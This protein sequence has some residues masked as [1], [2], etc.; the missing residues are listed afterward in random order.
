MN[1]ILV[2]AEER[3][4]CESLRAA[5]PETDLLF[6]EA[7]T[8]HVVRRLTS[9]RP[10]MVI[11]DD[12]PGLGQQTLLKVVEAAPGASCL[13]LSSRRDSETLA[14]FTLAGARQCIVKPFS[15]DELRSAVQHVTGVVPKPAPVNVPELD[16]QSSASA[17]NQHQMALRWLGRT[18]GHMQNPVRISQ[19]LVDA[20]V[21]IFDAVRSAVLL[22]QQGLVRIVASHGIPEAVTAQLRL[23][24]SSGLMRSFD[25][26]ACLIDRGAA[27]DAPAAAKEMQVLGAR[28]AVPILARGRVCGAILIG[29]KASGSDYTLEEKELLSA[30][31]R[32]ASTSFDNAQLYQDLSRQQTRLDTVLANITAGVVTVL[33]NKCVGMMNQSAE[34]I[35][36]LRAVDVL[37]RSVQKLGSGFADM[38]LRTLADGTPRL[39]QEIQDP[40]INATLGL[41][42]TPLGDQGVV[43]I[44][45]K[46]PGEKIAT[47]DVAYSPFWEY[48]ASR[49]AQEIKNPMVAVNT[50]AQL[51]PKKYDSEDFRTA[52]ADVVQK[53][54]SR[55]NNVVETLFDFAQHPRLVLQ[56]ANVQSTVQNVLE[57]FQQELGLRNISLRMEWD[58]EVTEAELDPIHFCRAVHNVVQNSIEAMPGGGTLE[59]ATHREGKN[60]ELVISDTGPG[61]PAQDASLV[62]MPFFSTKERGMGLGLTVANRI[63]EQHE[64][65]LELRNTNHKGG[66]F[67]LRLPAGGKGAGTPSET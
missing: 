44:F 34:R 6:F 11:V 5:L 65:K 36:Q 50:F 8:E 53:E 35:L 18:F 39:R 49:V 24:F 1:I 46:I 66:V 43:I 23:S 10:D 31:A 67:A 32:S 64:G 26:N 19:S 48:L 45:S 47:E 13:V 58:P 2:A 14:S 33:A 52:F 16:P 41:S 29:E 51:L 4:I 60:L 20:T 3:G 15:C 21:D 40:A 61:I 62:F 38:A 59:I 42:A 55:I 54:V 27:R 9:I 25:E 7:T 57:G 22:E 63:M 28:L 12:A 30:V 37:G 17:L 56:K